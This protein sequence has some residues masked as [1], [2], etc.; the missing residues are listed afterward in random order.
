MVAEE[1]AQS[2]QR[3]DGE[4]N[5]PGLA[6]LQTSALLKHKSHLFLIH[7]YCREANQQHRTTHTV[8]SQKILILIKL[9]I[10]FINICLWF[11]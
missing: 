8:T 4:G 11:I 6:A 10:T 1:W 9:D 3:L 7:I 2:R 5:D